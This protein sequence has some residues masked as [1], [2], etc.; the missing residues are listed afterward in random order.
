MRWR[1]VPWRQRRWAI[2]GVV[3]KLEPL[4]VPTEIMA[5]IDRQYAYEI[6][7]GWLYGVLD[8]LESDG[9]L[10]HETKRHPDPE[11]D[12]ARRGRRA[13]FW[14]ATGKPRP[15]RPAASKTGWDPGV[16]PA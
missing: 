7:L 16:V 3:R 15:V 14:F 13:A 12:A 1:D 8:R 11:R 4:A 2:Y 9:Y 5:E 10:R 6:S